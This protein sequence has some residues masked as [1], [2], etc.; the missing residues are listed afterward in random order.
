[1]TDNEKDTRSK[2]EDLRKLIDYH[3]YRYYALDQPEITD[4]EY[5]RIFR[6]LV[7]IENEDRK[8]VV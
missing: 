4:S 2:I 3:N 1:M 5:D 8:S 7:N 6:E